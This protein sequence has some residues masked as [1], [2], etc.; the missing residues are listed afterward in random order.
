[1]F[2]GANVFWPLM[3]K[4]A[5]FCTLFGFTEREIRLT[6]G[7]YLK[8]KTGRDLDAVMEELCFC[9]SGY[10]FHPEQTQEDTVFNSYSI[11]SYLA[12]GTLDQHWAATGGLSST[13]IEMLGGL[14]SAELLNGFIMSSREL[15][16]PIVAGPTAQNWRQ[17]AFQSGYA[18]I[19]KPSKRT[20][21]GFD[22]P[23]GSPNV[24]V[25]LW[26]DS[27]LPHRSTLSTRSAPRLYRS[28]GGHLR[29]LTLTPRRRP[30]PI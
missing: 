14:Q 18:T 9:Y 11:V 7:D 26:L 30:W 20:V 3:E 6:Y 2:S 10:R 22:V 21:A 4:S 16:A 12:F 27:A 8:S 13:T 17:L 5:E 28:T 15:Y 29:P 23:L 24:E 25:R 19:L 1:M